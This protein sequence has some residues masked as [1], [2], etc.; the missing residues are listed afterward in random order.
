MLKRKGII[1]TVVENGL[2][3][4]NHYKQKKYDVLL[5]DIHMPVMGGLETAKKIREMDSQVPIIALTAAVLPEE[6]ES[7]YAAGINKIV[8]KPIAIDTLLKTINEVLAQPE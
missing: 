6:K 3:M 1:P 5:V 7:Y 4:I 2:E 8:E